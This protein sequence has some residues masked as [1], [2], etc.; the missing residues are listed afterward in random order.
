MCY[1][2][3]NSYRKLEGV[4]P[5]DDQLLKLAKIIIKEKNLNISEIELIN[6]FSGLISSS[7]QDY[8]LNLEQPIQQQ[9][10]PED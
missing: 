8:E 9:R 1:Y 6:L 10:H 7:L 5:M 2:L 4:G 3:S